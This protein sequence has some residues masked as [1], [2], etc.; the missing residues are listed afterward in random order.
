MINNPNHLAAYRALQLAQAAMKA[1][2]K[3]PARQYAVQAAQ[4]APDLEEVWLMLAALAAPRASI[5]YLQKALEINPHSE[6][7]RK[8]MVWAVKRLRERQQAE[9]TQPRPAVVPIPAPQAAAAAAPARTRRAPYLTLLLLVLC[10]VGLWAVW[11]GVTPARAIFDGIFSQPDTAPSW[12][13]VDIAKPTYTLTP[14][15][16]PTETNTPLPTPTFTATPLP[17][18]TETPLPTDTPTETPAPT[19]TLAPTTE[20]PTAEIPVSD[21]TAI[22]TEA[23][24]PP[25]SFRPAGV[26]A[27][28]NWIDVDLT[29]QMLYTYTGDTLIG[30]YV[31]STGTWEHPTVT[32]QYRVYWKLRYK[33]M[34]GPGYYLPD[35]P[36]T[37]FFYQG[38][39]IHGT[40]WHN[41]FGTPMSHGCVNLSIPDSEVV[42][43]FSQVGTL[44]N[45]HY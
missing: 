27:S 28:E 14:T 35:V 1:G 12:M 30:S 8:G 13:Q 19:E 23:P 44:V 31:V 16:T 20:A 21:A 25:V 41:N 43:N 37:M 39:A 4:L 34:A 22:A 2:Q 45:V 29:N 42:Y 7:A 10:M 11:Q 18:D 17:T 40:Y 3:Q 9:K 36:F 33:D 5:A 32:G 38:Y 24:P 26:G 6:R 15:D